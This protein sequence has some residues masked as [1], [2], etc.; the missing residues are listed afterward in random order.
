MTPEPK[1]VASPADLDALVGV[2]VTRERPEVFWEDSHGHFQFD[3]EMEARRA[4]ADPYYQRF[5]PDVD[6]SHMLVREVRSFRP[7][8]TD[9]GAN[10]ILVEKATARFGSML[11]S[12]EHG[13]WHVAFGPHVSA[14]ARTPAVAICLAALSAA[15]VA[16]DVSHDRIDSLL[17]A[18]QL[19]G[20]VAAGTSFHD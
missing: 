19:P 20:A 12:R 15:G 17:V 5:L 1:R 3:T 18:A 9:P 4:I 16:V 14:S 8:C 6:W 11:V 13:Q 7:Y 10:W 2:Y